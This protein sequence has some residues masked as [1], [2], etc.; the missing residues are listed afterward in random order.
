[1]ARPRGMAATRRGRTTAYG[2]LVVAAAL[3]CATPAAAQGT[4]GA[5]AED[6][7]AQ[8][9]LSDAPPGVVVRPAPLLRPWRCTRNCQDSYSAAS[10][11]MLRLRGKYLGRTF[12][13]IFQGAPGEAD[14]VAAA[15]LRRSKKAVSV[16]VP[17]GA[18]SGPIVVSD[19]DGMQS[20]PGNP[21]LALAAPVSLK[22]AGGQPTIEVQT[23]ARR[24][25]F[26]AARPATVSYVVHAAAPTHVVVELIRVSD[27]AVVT[28]WDAGDVA[29]ET[30]QTMSWDGTVGG[31]LQ[32]EGQYSFRVSAVDAAGVRAVSAQSG[33]APNPAAFR[34]LRNEF[35]IRGP[36]GYGEFAARFGGGRGHQGQDVF[37]A[38]GTPLVAARGGKVE[39]KQY[40]ARAGHYIVVDGERTGVDYTYMHLRAPALVD[41]GDRVRTG[42]LIGYVGRTGDATACHLHFEMWTAPGWYDGGHAFDPLPSLLTW[43]KMS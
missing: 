38:C 34:F 7:V 6:P 27:G 8:P 17:L 32:K 35:P 12:E 23:R 43:D 25:F 20:R 26:D 1:M 39:F 21:A 9:K 24:A 19:R 5:S 33:D 14:D 13:V 2:A 3:I 22:V 16:R 18:L 28:S 36:H 41:A 30:T 42:Q 29:P 15:P 31:V 4:G 11:A 10:G 40:H 37:A